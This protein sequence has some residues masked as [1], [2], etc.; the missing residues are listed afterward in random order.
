MNNF[1]KILAAALGC[2]VLLGSGCSNSPS[3]IRNSSID[4]TLY[5]E[6][7]SA[8]SAFEIPDTVNKSL[9]PN[10]T[11]LGSRDI[12]NSPAL[13]TYAASVNA[14]AE[15]LI[16]IERVSDE[17]YESRLSELINSDLSP[18]LTDK[19]DNSFPLLMSRNMY[20]DLTSYMD[21]SA[22]QWDEFAKYIEH[23]KFKGSSCFFPTSVTVLP[24]LLVYDKMTFVQ[25]NIPDP[26]KLWKKGEWTWESFDECTEQFQTALDSVNDIYGAHIAENVFATMG[27][28]LIS[29][30]DTGKLS[31]N[32]FNNDR[33]T[34]LEDFFTHFSCNQENQNI[35][36][37][38]DSFAVFMS[39]DES[40]I[41]K[42]RRAEVSIGI[43][44]YPKCSQTG[45]YTVKAVT[46]GFLVPKGAKNIT[47]AASFI[48]SSRLADDSKD[49]H[50]FREK[51]MKQYGLLRSDI[52][53][54]EFIRESGDMVPL[55]VDSR[56][57][58][59]EANAVMSELLTALDNM[60][61]GSYSLQSDL[62]AIDRSLEKI[63]AVI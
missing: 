47:G 56:C 59:S 18:D 57:L 63:N 37:I 7:S 14:D 10:I 15:S 54:I 19:R 61:F 29:R 55:I 44:P 40:V 5:T 26:E 50:R 36:A 4:V 62:S 53:W 24:Q 22:P 34:Y 17:E 9:S 46:D 49:G 23:Y 6:E 45:E 11:Y 41:G 16:T 20:E 27:N 31:N 48:N 25:Y 1:R 13:R 3:N 60:Q 35:S 58:D 43:V 33:F 28:S 21:I 42:L 12:N 32:A 39:A 38:M 2:A 51:Q 52:E 30:D 8:V